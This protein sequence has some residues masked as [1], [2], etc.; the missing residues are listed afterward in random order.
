M[1]R[2]ISS[3]WDYRP[4]SFQLVLVKVQEQEI[5]RARAMTTVPNSIIVEYVYCLIRRCNGTLLF[6]KK[7]Q[8]V[9][10]F[11]EF[12]FVVVLGVDSFQTGKRKQMSKK[13]DRPSL[14]SLSVTTAATRVF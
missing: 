6:I 5:E 2:P 11:C 8:V 9:F 7:K 14:L 13:T 3:G 1:R 10:L 12:L 4:S